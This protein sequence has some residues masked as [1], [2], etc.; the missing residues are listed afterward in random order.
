MTADSGSSSNR[1]A[2]CPLSG[3]KRT[4]P[5]RPGIDPLHDLS[6]SIVA[7]LTCGRFSKRALAG[8]FCHRI[9]CDFNH[10]RVRSF[11]LADAPKMPTNFGLLAKDDG[12]P[13]LQ[14]KLIM[15]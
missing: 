7:R 6:F 13:R 11:V 8:R 4:W 1:Y 5:N 14:A 2:E 12:Q 9:K 3:V 15:D 10:I